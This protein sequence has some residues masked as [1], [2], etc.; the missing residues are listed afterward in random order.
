MSDTVNSLS[1]LQSLAD[2]AETAAPAIV[3]QQAPRA[4][5]GR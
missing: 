4:P 3:H 5:P 1:D 2:G